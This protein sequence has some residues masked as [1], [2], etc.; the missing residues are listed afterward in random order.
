MMINF[1]ADQIGQSLRQRMTRS[2]WLAIALAFGVMG[3]FM[4]LA[5][6]LS[7]AYYD[8]KI[9]LNTARHVFDGYYYGYWLL[10]VFAVLDKLPFALSCAIWGSLNI[11]G[12]FFAARVFGGKPVLA[13]PSYQMFYTLIYGSI[14]GVIVGALAVCWWGIHNRKW[15]IAGLAIALASA[16]YQIGITGSLILLLLA[17]LTWKERARILIVPV[18]I[19]LASLLLYPG[20]LPESLQNILSAPPNTN[21]SVSLW[22][23]IGPWALL[24]WIPSLLVPFSKS[25][26]LVLLTV[27]ASL[28]LPYFQ[29][30]DLLLLL[31]LPIGWVGLLGYI[32]YLMPV[33]GWFALQM[34]ALLPM[35]VYGA[36]FMPRVTAWVRRLFDHRTDHLDSSGTSNGG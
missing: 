4:G 29:Q 34:L 13:L 31:V 33:Y 15:E 19:G 17:D 2:E 5:P 8:Y 22:R 35:A 6:A 24:L 36:V 12:I 7:F 25:Q 1:T 16:K 10:P 26:R 14:S 28:A 32:G 11:L 27:T 30:S 21:G 18:L 3:G 20:W 23:W 9:Y